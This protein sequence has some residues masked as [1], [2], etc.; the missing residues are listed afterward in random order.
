MTYSHQFVSAEKMP[1]PV[2]KV[3]CVG[4]NYAAHAKE[5]NNPVPTSPLLFMKPST[6]LVALEEAISLP[7]SGGVCHFETEIAVL[8]GEVISTESVEN[9]QGK[10]AGYGLGLD[11]TLRELQN[12]LK[13]NGHPWEIAKAFD[14]ACPL[15]GFVD[16][17]TVPDPNKLG[18][19]TTVNGE[20]RQKG[21][22][23]EMISPVLALISAVSFHFTLLPGDV[24]MTGTPA[25]VGPLHCN[26]ILNLQLLMKNDANTERSLAEFAS[27]VVG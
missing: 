6:S 7:V 15:S 17:A 10:I 8:I 24:V 9:I 27:R 1:L 5:L 22:A 19:V 23:E 11:L 18:L 4:R 12:A 3:V 2:G 21:F 26:D 25:G 14:G 16:A 20:V 13:S